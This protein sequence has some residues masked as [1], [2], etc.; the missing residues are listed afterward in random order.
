LKQLNALNI[1]AF[2]YTFNFVSTATNIFSF[3]QYF[4]GGKPAIGGDWTLVDMNGNLVTQKSFEGKWTLLYFG[5]A[6]CPDICP[7]EMVKMGKL[8]EDL[9]RE[10]PD[11]YKQVRPLFV[12]VDPA[13]DSIKAL[14]AF[15]KDFHPD[16]IFL[17]GTPIQVQQM[18]KKYRVYVSKAE[19][20]GDDY[21]SSFFIRMRAAFYSKWRCLTDPRLSTIF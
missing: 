17:T 13:R 6:R 12:T 16:M 7:S 2:L 20:E 11:L 21:V 9:K 4:T 8:L 10:M 14:Q 3:A 5:F 18:T 1:A 15:A 19:E